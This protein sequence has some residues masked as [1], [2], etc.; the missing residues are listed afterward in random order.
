[1][2]VYT[3]N[4]NSW[5]GILAM[6]LLDQIDICVTKCVMTASRTAHMTFTSTPFS[7]K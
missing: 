2:R 3:I 6:V 7:V 5:I 4:N 1:M